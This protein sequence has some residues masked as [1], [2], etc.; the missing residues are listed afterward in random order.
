[1]RLLV[2]CAAA[3]LCACQPNVFHTEVKGSSTIQGDPSPIAGLLNAFPGVSNFSNI[4]FNQ[5]QDFKNQGVSKDQVSSVKVESVKLQITS[6][7]DQDFTFLTSMKFDASTD[8]KP[9]V[10]VAQ[11]DGID[12]LNL[13]APNPTLDMDVTNAELRDYVTAPNMSINVTGNGRLPKQDTTLEATVG[14]RVEIKVF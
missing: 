12:K 9:A 8:G 3:M 7:N 2:L 11:K 14:L 13:P 1:M 4:D 6:P 10:T 5:N